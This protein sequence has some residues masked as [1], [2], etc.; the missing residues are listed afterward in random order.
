MTYALYRVHSFCCDYPGCYAEEEHAEQFKA[1]ARRIMARAGWRI[2]GDGR[3][4]CPA[5]ASEA[6]EMPRNGAGRPGA[7]P[8]TGGGLPCCCGGATDAAEE[9][10]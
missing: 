4:R 9:S 2:G 3:D 5:H 1:D 6:G 10:G 7:A 8:V